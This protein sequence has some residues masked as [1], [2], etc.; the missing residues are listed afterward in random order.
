MAENTY[1]IEHA[2][3]GR[4]K[5]KKCKSTI[6]KDELR[7][8]KHF[9]SERFEEGGS[10]TDWFHPSCI[11]EHLK[12]ARKTTRKIEDEADISGFVLLDDDEKAAIRELIAHR[13]DKP[14]KKSK[15]PAKIARL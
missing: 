15:S 4:S 9:P 8:A 1:S 3:T 2:K 6:E 10:A 14:A 12:R 11:F 13:D 7:V 5:C